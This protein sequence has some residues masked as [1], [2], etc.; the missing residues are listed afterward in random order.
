SPFEITHYGLDVTLDPKAHSLSAAATLRV[1]SRGKEVR[2]LDF[3]LH[4]ECRPTSVE[5]DGKPAR[6]I[7]PNDL[8]AVTP[9]R[10]LAGKR[11]A[12]VR[13]TYARTGDAAMSDGAGYISPEGIYFISEARWYPATGELDFRSPVRLHATVPKG[14][15]VVS[16]GALKGVRKDEKTSTFQ[17]ETDRPASMV[18]LAAAKYVQQ[19][20]TIPPVNGLAPTRGPLTISCYTYPEHR[21]SGAAFLKE[22]AAI[23]R[24]YERRYG[25][26]PFEKLA[27][28]EIPVFPGGYGST[29]FVMLLDQSFGMEQ[30][31]QE[32]LAHE[33]AHQW[34]GNSVFP[35]GLGAAWLTEAFANYSAWMYEAAVKGNPRILQKRVAKGTTTFFE[36][37]AAR[38]DQT[39]YESDP[40]LPVGARTERIYEKGAVVLHML[41]R[42]IGDAA[43]QRTLRRFA[44]DHRFGLAKIEDFRKIAE[45]EH[46]KP[47]GWFFD[48]W[49][50]RK[51]GMELTYSFETKALSATQNEAVLRITQPA[52]AYRARMK[53]T[54]QVDNSVET[55]EIEITQSPQE[56]R[57]PVRGKLQS[58]LLDP[59]NDFLMKP[60]RWVVGDSE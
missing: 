55:R 19:S 11:E 32:F 52:P 16:I 35:Q 53:V 59:D 38:G 23:A 51:G 58:V 57:F 5:V 20:T 2:T 43:F 9:E 21:A 42:E 34:W 10:P 3:S 44:A 36:A 49:L 4:P 31:P 25:T 50:G 45:A 17:W 33:I 12:V 40:Y 13:I 18:S 56:F 26:Y 7:H 28:A 39:I 54:L 37:M 8:L 24:Y 27:L 29:S 47:L 41:R 6:F 15:T 46:G 30:V 22:A 60:P 14:Y 1:R 48:Q